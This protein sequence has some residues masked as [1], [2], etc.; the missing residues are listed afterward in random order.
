MKRKNRGKTKIAGK[1]KWTWAGHLIRKE[2]LM[3]R[4]PFHTRPTGIEKEEDPH[5]D[6]VS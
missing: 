5:Y 6:K 1:I 2:E 3:S 4:W